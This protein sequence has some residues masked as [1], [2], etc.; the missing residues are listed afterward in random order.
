MAV[1]LAIVQVFV[2]GLLLGA[3]YALVAS[4]LTLIWGVMNVVNFAHGEF[5]MLG[6]YVAFWAFTLL[7]AGPISFSVLAVLLLFG[8]GIVVYLALI[9]RVLRGP[10][11]AQIL[12]T[13][14]LM[15]FLR[16]LAFWAFSPNYRTLPPTLLGG[17]VDIG[18]VFVSLPQLVA[19]VVAVL[20]TVG[21]YQLITKTRLGQQLLAVAEDAEAAQLMGIRP[22]R[23][24]ALAWGMAAAGTGLAGA[25]LATF[26]YTFPEVGLNFSLIAFVVVTLGGFGSIPG[27]MLAGLII[28]LVESLS[29]FFIGPVYKELVVFGLFL[30]VLWLRP[31]GLLG[32]GIA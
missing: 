7:G 26:Y 32:R 13:F 27:A 23:I 29:A 11:L 4:G 21:M 16:Y 15:L 3:I 20:V 12:S 17:T 10:M 8:L 22:H 5:L 28:G 9:R 19:G 31:Q 1:N 6:M 24:Y 30:A 14:G 2:N 25:L 18:G